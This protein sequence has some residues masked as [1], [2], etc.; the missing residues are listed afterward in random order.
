[1]SNYRPVNLIQNEMV[2]GV[3]A[4]RD[5]IA[6]FEVTAGPDGLSFVTPPDLPNWYDVAISDRLR[7]WLI[8]LRLLRNVPL[9]YL[10]PDARLLPPESIRFFF[11]DQNWTERVLDGVF[12]AA[13]AGTVA[14]HFHVAM[15]QLV[16][17]SLD[18]QM[19]AMATELDGQWAPGTGVLTGMLIRSELVRRWPDLIVT[20][21][22]GST[23][24]S[25]VIPVLRAE[26]ISRDVFI[27]VFAGQPNLVHV[28][29]PH[30]GVR[31]GVEPQNPDAAAV[32]YQVDKRTK[33][34][35]NAAGGGSILVPLRDPKSQRVINVD[36]FATTVG[37]HLGGPANKAARFVAL[38]LEQR[39]YVQ[40]FTLAVDEPSG[41]QPLPTGADGKYVTTTPLRNG[42]RMRMRNLIARQQQQTDLQGD[43]D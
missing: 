12:S 36:L 20:A 37:Q 26:P 11:V 42:R 21:Y 18:M 6:S 15:L 29:E 24:D 13:S 41:S 9:S 30:V 43:L 2:T 31:F 22:A 39:P 23:P 1:V 7:D 35:Q 10:V 16:R 19:V 27:A 5:W 25:G 34:G 3:Q 33:T 4:L 17:Q 40:S 32:Q 14:S 28:R 38:H 8:G